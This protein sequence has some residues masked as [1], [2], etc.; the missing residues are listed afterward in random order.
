MVNPNSFRPCHTSLGCAAGPIG[1]LWSWRRHCST[2]SRRRLCVWQ[3]TR[4][5]Q[6]GFYVSFI[7]AK[8]CSGCLSSVNE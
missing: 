1:Y 2:I 7:R 4:Y 6:I 3:A 8:N 5:V